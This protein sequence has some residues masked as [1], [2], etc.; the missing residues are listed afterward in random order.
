[1]A[2]LFIVPTPIGNLEDITL[3]AI[4]VLRECDFICAEDTRVSAH[5]LQHYQIDKPMVSYHNFNEHDITERIIA[6]IAAGERCCLISDCGTPGLS[7]PGFLL[8]R[9][10][11]N[12][13]IKVDALPGAVAFM[14]A[15]LQSGFPIHPF[16]FEGFLP[17]KKGRKT[18]LERLATLEYTII[19]YESPYRILKLL[20]EIHT[21]IGNRRVSVSREL[22]K[23]FEETLRGTAYELLQH[24]SKHEP[25]G[26]FVVIIEAANSGKKQ[27]T[28]RNGDTD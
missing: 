6:R 16:L 27:K 11:I 24:F 1:M 28:P 23:K 2:Q 18:A 13:Q 3:R 21:L 7:D 12:H 9:A 14:P 20:E 22:T 25:R 19:L 8:I 26:E 15:L 17:H 4:R 5:L 10:A